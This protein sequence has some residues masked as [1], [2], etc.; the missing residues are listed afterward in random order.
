MHANLTPTVLRNTA[1]LIALTLLISAA[2][3]HASAA[4][5]QDPCEKLEQAGWT[6]ALM[7]RTQELC[8]MRQILQHANKPEV[9]STMTNGAQADSLS[10]LPGPVVRNAAIGETYRAD[11]WINLRSGPGVDHG[12]IGRAL[13]DDEL[14]TTGVRV[15]DWWQV[16]YRSPRIG[17]VT[18]WV[19]S[20]WVRRKAE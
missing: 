20:Q 12:V 10:P 11:T 13:Q 19:F 16:V 15:G 9:P 7:F 14:S 5:S 18:G 8:Q 6:Q 3:Q 17:Q 4:A 2:P 1:T